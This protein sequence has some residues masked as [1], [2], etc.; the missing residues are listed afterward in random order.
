VP[1]YVPRRDFHLGLPA[2]AVY[3]GNLS[4]THILFRPEAAVIP[5]DRPPDRGRDS[6]R[7]LGPAKEK[8]E[9]YDSLDRCIVGR[10]WQFRWELGLIQK[11]A[12]RTHAKFREMG[13]RR[14]C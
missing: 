2:M 14:K 1:L 6:H 4:W 9:R 8:I 12:P 13:G 5:P 11:E 3:T 7:A 10:C